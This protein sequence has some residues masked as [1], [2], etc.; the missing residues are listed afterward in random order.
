MH[1][2]KAMTEN[3]RQRQWRYLQVPPVHCKPKETQS[4]SLSW[5][6]R[7]WGQNQPELRWYDR[8]CYLQV[9]CQ[10][11][12]WEEMHVAVSRQVSMTGQNS[13][14]A[15]GWHITLCR[16]GRQKDIYWRILATLILWSLVN[17]SGE[18][19][20]LSTG[21]QV[22]IARTQ[23]NSTGHHTV[24]VRGQK[25]TLMNSCN[26]PLTVNKSEEKFYTCQQVCDYK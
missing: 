2:S 25:D 8:M 20:H 9:F 21:M 5:G 17:E 11:T 13:T 19:L 7:Q 23:V 1:I 4:W 15:A 22:L 16:W 18:T 14:F 12:D 6:L 26:P 3:Q 24:Q 10:P